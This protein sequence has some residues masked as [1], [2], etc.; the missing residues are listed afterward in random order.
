MKI[1]AIRLHN[2]NSLKGQVAIEFDREPFVHTGL[3]AITGDTGAG[4]TTILDAI[5]LALYAKTSRDHEKE[6]MSNGTTECGAEVEFSNE[7]GRFL[8]RWQQKR[9]NR[10]AEQLPVTRDLAQWDTPTS[11]W[12]II[13]SGKTEVDGKGGRGAVEEHLGLGYE[14]FKRTVLLAQ[15]EFAAFLHADERTRSA[16]LERL[17][18]T[19]IYTRLSRAAFERAKQTRQLHDQLMVEK[20]ARQV[21]SPDEVQQLNIELQEQRELGDRADVE[22]VQLRTQEALLRQIATLQQ[23]LTDLQRAAE[24]LEAEQTAFQP[25]ALRLQYHQTILPL[26]TTAV[27]WQEALTNVQT[28]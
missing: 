24:R 1:H 17:T 20:N 16:V 11:T 8:A 5:T 2:L 12:R 14:Q 25:E 3:F 15:G 22:L 19:E 23:A 18:D 4:K 28:G 27:Q 26:K 9:S 10:K 6:V 13:A 7:K 21:L